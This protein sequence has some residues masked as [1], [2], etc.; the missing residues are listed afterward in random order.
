[1][2][3]SPVDRVVPLRRPGEPGARRL[4][5]AHGCVAVSRE[6]EIMSSFFGGRT[7]PFRILRV[8]LVLICS[9]LPVSGMDP[10]WKGKEVLLTRAG[11]MLE[12]PAGEK[13]APRT[14]GVAKDLTFT[15]LKD[16]DG[17]ILV[18]SRRQRGWIAKG[19]AVLLDQAVTHFTNQLALHPDDSHAF[20]ARGVALMSK[21]ESDKGLADLNKAIEL[22]PKA[23]LAYYHRANLA[24][25]RM[26]YDKALED[27]NTVIRNDPEFD[28]AYHVR[29]WIYYRRNDY[30]KALVDY[31]K[32]ISLAP[33]ETVFYRDRGNIAMMRKQYDQAVADFS[34]S[35]ELDPKYS[36]PLLQRSRAWMLKKEYG[37]A[38]ADYKKAVELAPKDA[39]ASFYH[40][41]LALFLAGCPEAKF[42]NGKKALEAAE[43]A[44]QLAKGPGEMSALAAAHAELGQFDKAIEWQTKAGDSAP[45]AFKDAYR[46]RLKMYQDQKPYRFE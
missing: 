19:D 13:I 37:K 46:N 7:M 36:S 27:Y 44:Y 5:A 10:S 45:V 42:R 12:V 20:T 24:Y 35:I 32:A 28:W 6:K 4:H 11:V 43:K 18:E 17:R 26:E 22:D 15:V 38:L 34:K 16:K 30:D 9:G 8:A 1:M 33:T 21:K 31:E 3:A 2:E 39:T 29:G 41:G 23:T 25:E 40:A 14:S